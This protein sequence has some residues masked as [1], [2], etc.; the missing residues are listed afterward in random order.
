MLKSVKVFLYAKQ[1]NKKIQTFT[2]K[3]LG[4][5]LVMTRK[6]QMKLWKLHKNSKFNKDDK[7]R[8]I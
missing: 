8:D 2:I 5:N 6:K 1:Y 4:L 7:N 3:K